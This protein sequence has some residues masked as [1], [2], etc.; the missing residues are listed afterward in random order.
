[1]NSVHEQCSNSAQNYA[2]LATMSSLPRQRN[3]CR[4]RVTVKSLLRQRILC[5]DRI[6][7]LRTRLCLVRVPAWSCVWLECCHRA[8]RPCN[9]NFVATRL[10]HVMTRPDCAMSR[11][12]SAVPC[13]DTTSTSR[14]KLSHDLERHVA[15]WEPQALPKF[16]AHTSSSCMRPGLVVCAPRAL[17]PRLP[18]LVVYERAFCHGQLCY[19]LKIL[20]RDRNSPYSI[21]LYCDI[22]LLYRDIISPCFG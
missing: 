17:S 15:T 13:R 10:C 11:H 1:M 20:C 16:V 6:S 12:D 21:Q 5:C 4:D 3:L 14:P 22:E 9:A 18:G 19:D 8:P 7:L 2:L